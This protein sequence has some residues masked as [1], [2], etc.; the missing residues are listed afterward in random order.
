MCPAIVREV[1]STAVLVAA[2]A[3]GPTAAEAGE[4]NL[5][6]RRCRRV[7]EN[8]PSHSAIGGAQNDRLSSIKI[9]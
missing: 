3:N 5:F 4:V 6:Q 7:V 2:L 8:S 9:R 1:D